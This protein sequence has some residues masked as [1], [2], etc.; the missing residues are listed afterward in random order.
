MVVVAAEAAA[1]AR[2]VDAPAEAGPEARRDGG[3]EERVDPAE[4]R[5]LNQE[6]AKSGSNPFAVFFKEGEG[7]ND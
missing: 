6:A 4:L 1:D 3:R 7:K 2:A 5:K